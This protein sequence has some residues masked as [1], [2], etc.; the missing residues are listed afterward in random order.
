MSDFEWLTEDEAHHLAEELPPA[1][2]PRRWLA[3]VIVLVGLGAGGIWLS[4]FLDE[5]V[6]VAVETVQSEVQA[7]AGLLLFSAE[8]N[9][10]ELLTGLLA[11]E[12]RA[13][14]AA[15]TE[16]LFNRNLFDRTHYGLHRTDDPPQLNGIRLSADL[17]SAEITT[18]VRYTSTFES[19]TL[20]I[21]L[22]LSRDDSGWKL[23]A[24][25][26]NFTGSI[27]TLSNY[28]FDL[29][30]P[31]RDEAIIKE[32][33]L[34]DLMALSFDRSPQPRRSPA[35]QHPRFTDIHDRSQPP[36]SC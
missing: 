27:R 1:V 30:Y 5:R 29:T 12:D 36:D 16:L 28:S 8:N 9:D 35:R 3:V 25:D 10:T 22:R 32:K 4:S 20:T 19:V 17:N 18:T 34:P 31:A 13:W 7:A 21:P 23:A 24:P 14:H 26:R 33:L 6:T 15:Q 11:T 2:V